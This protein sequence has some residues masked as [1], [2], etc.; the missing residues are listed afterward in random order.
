MKKLLALCILVCTMFSFVCAQ[1][2]TPEEQR[3]LF[4]EQCKQYLGTPYKYGGI[5]KTGMDCSGFI[6]TSAKQSLGIKLPRRAEDLYN[7]TERL[8]KEQLQPGDFLFFKAA[9]TVN[10]AAVYLGNDEFIHAASDGP[11]TGVIIS[12]LSDSYWNTTF[13]GCGKFLPVATHP[14]KIGKVFPQKEEAEVVQVETPVKAEVEDLPVAVAVVEE[15]KPAEPEP[16]DEGFVQVEAVPAGTENQ[17]EVFTAIPV[18]GTIS[19]GTPTAEEIAAEKQREQLAAQE[20]ALAQAQA[21][22][23]EQARALAEAQAQLR[24]A[25]N[26]Q[27]QAEAQAQAYAKAQAEA[28]AQAQ[29]AY[30][31][32]Q[33]QASQQAQVQ[34]QSQQALAL[35]ETTQAAKEAA[36][37]AR[38]AT[39]AAREATAAAQEA[40]AAANEATQASKEALKVADTSYRS[41]LSFP[42]VTIS[43]DGFIY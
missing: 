7:A 11:K 34:A 15:K 43:T 19:A 23:E 25:Q 24:A 27:A 9:N 42:D 13:V 10:H 37:A 8:E 26:A 1:E 20:A 30:T 5:S 38:E 41:I 17:G 6:F 2:L 12:K 16:V 33:L 29:A 31:Q 36:A 28:Q 21:Q 35:Q 4:L 18:P 14:E 39:A 40:K 3:T 32:A 22:A